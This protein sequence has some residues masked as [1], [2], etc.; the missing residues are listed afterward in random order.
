[1][2]GRPPRALRRNLGLARRP[3]A[4]RARRVDLGVA[5]AR[6]KGMQSLMLSLAFALLG[7][8][9]RSTPADSALVE[10]FRTSDR[11]CSARFTPR[12]LGPDN[13]QVT[14][15]QVCADLEKCTGV[16]FRLSEEARRLTGEGHLGM[17]AAQ[18][19]GSARDAIDLI[20]QGSLDLDWLYAESGA[21]L[22]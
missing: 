16:S 2:D 3:G 7:Q 4:L 13:E 5:P 6:M 22:V 9:S 21:L 12:W 8:G 19:E 14:F 11:I 17:R 18:P 15:E 1:A 20:P 10:F